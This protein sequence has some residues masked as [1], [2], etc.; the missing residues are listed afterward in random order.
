MANGDC[1]VGAKHAEQ[2]KGIKAEVAEVKNDYKELCYKI[3]SIN[4][5][6]NRLL[7]GVAIACVL[8]AVNVIIG[9]IG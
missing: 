8:L 1:V 6:V 5:N 4:T 7:G 2:I 9:A 3:N